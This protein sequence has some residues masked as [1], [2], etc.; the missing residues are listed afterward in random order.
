MVLR[1]RG[2]EGSLTFPLAQPL[3]RL[4]SRASLR[5]PQHPKVA[6]NEDEPFRD[7][8]NATLQRLELW[9][10]CELDLVDKDILRMDSED[11]R[12]EFEAKIK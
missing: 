5:S 1:Q 3:P 6:V 11:G 10:S 12:R 7:V 2:A 8:L 4:A 9:P